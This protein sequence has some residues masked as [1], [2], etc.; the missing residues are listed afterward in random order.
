MITIIKYLVQIIQLV[1]KNPK[2]FLLYKDAATTESVPES[3]YQ[4][5]M[6]YLLQ[7]FAL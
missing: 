3:E 2:L 5:K 6:I 1:L 4:L 7:S